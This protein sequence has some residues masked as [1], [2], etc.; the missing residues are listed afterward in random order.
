MTPYRA[1]LVAAVLLLGVAGCG[2]EENL[3]G[4]DG[5]LD[6]GEAAWSLTLDYEREHEGERTPFDAMVDWSG[7]YDARQHRIH[8]ESSRTGT[9]VIDGSEVAFMR[10]VE[11]PTETFEVVEAEGCPGF[12]PPSQGG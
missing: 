1:A 4:F 2:S 5:S 10:V 9:V 11:L 6:C 12:E 7:I 3:E 8:V